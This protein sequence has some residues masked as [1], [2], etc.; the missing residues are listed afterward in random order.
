M[1][2]VTERPLPPPRLLTL[3]PASAIF[4]PHP[5]HEQ[6]QPDGPRVL[7]GSLSDVPPPAYRGSRPSQPPRLLGAHPVR[8]RGGGAS[9]SALHQGAGR[10]VRGGPLRCGGAPRRRR[11][12]ARSR[13][14]RPPP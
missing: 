9:R 3:P 13:P 10:G 6:L 8:G 2:G 1:P 14:A 4:C 11:L 5:S 12:A 7:G